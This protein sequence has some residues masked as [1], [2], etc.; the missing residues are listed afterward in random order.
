MSGVYSTWGLHLPGE[1]LVWLATTPLRLWLYR[2]QWLHGTMRLA[3][4]VSV[5]AFFGSI[6]V[7]DLRLIGIRRG[8][9]LGELARLV[10]PWTYAGFAVAMVSGVV[11]FLFDPIQTGSHTWFLPKLL[12][13]A[14][15]LV[16]IAVYHPH[17]FALSL[18]AVGPTRH[19]RTAGLLSLALWLAVIACAT[20][21]QVERPLVPSRT[22]LRPVDPT[23]LEE[24]ED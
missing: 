5:S 13:I 2:L 22:V 12:L 11:L 9:P 15:A 8:V 10:L 17:G 3:H 20:G 14:A 21:N 7:L 18:A 16:N 4:V 24:G 6:L 23:P 1:W 19:G